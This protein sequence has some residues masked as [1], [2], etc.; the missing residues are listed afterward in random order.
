MNK[1][2]RIARYLLSFTPQIDFKQNPSHSERL[3]NLSASIRVATKSITF[4]DFTEI[5]VHLPNAVEIK[6]LLIDVCTY[7]LNVLVDKQAVCFYGEILIM[8]PCL[9]CVGLFTAWI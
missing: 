3:E 5:K 4:S 7:S 8:R 2:Y 9:F 1:Y 6:F